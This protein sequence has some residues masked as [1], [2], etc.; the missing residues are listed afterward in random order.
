MPPT[1]R[2]LIPVFLVNDLNSTIEFYTTKLGFE[3][4]FKYG[5]PAFCGSV[6]NWSV[7]VHFEKSTLRSGIHVLKRTISSIYIF[8]STT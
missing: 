6:I 1:F 4:D 3:I 5:E 8:R 2:S 7:V